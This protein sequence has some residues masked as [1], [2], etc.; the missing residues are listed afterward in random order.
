[1]PPFRAASFPNP[2]PA[3]TH[4]GP[5]CSYPDI[6]HSADGSQNTPNGGSSECPSDAS[7]PLPHAASLGVSS[8]LLQALPTSSLHAVFL[9]L[10]PLDFA[11]PP[12]ASI[13]AHRP[14]VNPRRT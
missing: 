1:M 14:A 13:S 8:S 6:A 9:Q 4:S 5:D 12:S 2:P 11:L 7:Y 10:R 3:S